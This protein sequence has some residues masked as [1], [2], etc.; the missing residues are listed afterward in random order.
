ML[1][2]SG[3]PDRE[4]VLAFQR[5]GVE[6]IAVD[7]Y[8]GAPL[9]GIADQ[10][11]VLNMTDTDEV[12]ATIDRL[13]PEFVMT[14][15]DVVAADAL[16]AASKTRLTEVVLSTRSARLSTDREGM[17]RLA[18]D[19][20]GLPTAPFWF[21]GSVEELRAVA[22]HAGFPIVVKP[23]APSHGEGETVLWRE[24]DIESAWQR[25][26]AAGDDAERVLA[27]TVVEID[28][29][30]TLLTVRGAGAAGPTLNFCA[31]IGHRRLDG[32]AGQLVLESWQP[33]PMSPIALDAAKSI[34]ARIVK[35]LGG[36]GVFGVEL[37]VRG[38]EVYFSD[39]TVRPDD[40]ALV[41]QSTQRLAGFELQ[42][43]TILGL[44]TDTIMVSPGAA[45][46]T[47]SGRRPAAGAQPDAARALAE[48]LNVP[49]S[50]VV[51]FAHHDGHPRR[52]LGAALATASDVTTARERAGQAAAALSKLWPS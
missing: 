32:A 30:V 26:V 25:A 16:T 27:E 7:G 9:H 39:V 4:L 21:A 11:L 46:L 2:G 43:R 24:A 3:E 15:T 8:A 18:A 14:A 36:R 44:A 12:I 37:L 41:T 33:Q 42:A 52:R 51:M 34:A 28:H 17:R 22:R 40:T 10:S 6:V 29:E 49:E 31:P 45:R 47:Y 23:V 1:L 20:L 50:D 13:Q 19:E 35:A 48:A 38:D 5:L